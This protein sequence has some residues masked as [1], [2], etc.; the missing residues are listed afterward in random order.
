M[1]VVERPK[2]HVA[3]SFPLPSCPFLLLKVVCPLRWQDMEGS[4]VHTTIHS[5]NTEAEKDASCCAECNKH[6]QC[7]FWVR[8]TDS[9]QCWLKASPI[10]RIPLANMRGGYRGESFVVVGM[11]L[12]A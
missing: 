8:A 1:S 6:S 2:H 11:P 9:N 5:G 3:V 12:H 7:D 4:L 10:N